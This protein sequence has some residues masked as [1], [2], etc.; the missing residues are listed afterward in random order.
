MIVATRISD[1]VWNAANQTAVVTTVGL[2]TTYTGICLFN[3][4]AASS[5]VRAYLLGVGI[6]LSV[7]PVAASTIG[8]MGGYVAAGVTT[9]TTHLARVKKCGREVDNAICDVMDAGTLV[10]TPRLI[11]P[12]MGA[13]TAGA[14]PETTPQYIKIDGHIAIEPGG[15]VAIYTE[16]S[17]TGLFGFCWEEETLY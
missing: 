10:G 6:A 2:A 13:F 17:L 11:M 15:W 7:A 9:H 14:W 8:I 4:A 5:G 1:K 12:L 16:T 3:P